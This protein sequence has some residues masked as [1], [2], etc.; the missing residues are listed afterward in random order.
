MI[1]KKI[2]K[3]Y[4]CYD[5]YNYENNKNLRSFVENLEYEVIFSKIE[6]NI[7]LVLGWDGSLL[8][9]VKKFYK[10]DL[11][12]LWLN[13]WTTWFL[14]ND[15]K[16]LKNLLK[17]KIVKYPLLEVFYENDGK[18]Y[19]W[20]CFN[21]VNV[22]VWDGKVLDLK[23]LVWREK[24]LFRWDWVL[25]S[26]PAGSTWYNRSLFWPILEHGRDEFILTPKAEINLQK[27]VIFKN[28]KKVIIKNI[29]RLNPIE[30]Y[31]DS[32]KLWKNIKNKKVEILV[33]KSHREVRMIKM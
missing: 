20:V 17:Y 16:N 19:S 32:N 15:R 24:Y 4:I 26:T 9:A 27:S 14:L 31:V 12:F 3:N 23:V 22:T 30:V 25:V 33:K 18:K 5:S 10:R 13:F 2:W 29:H 21:E 7:V 1:T 6:E 11:I 28:T 8:R